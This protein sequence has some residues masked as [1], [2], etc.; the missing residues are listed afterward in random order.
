MPVIPAVRNLG[1]G[2]SEMC[3]EGIE[4]GGV[5]AVST[6][7]V[8]NSDK[9]FKKLCQNEVSD[10]VRLLKPES[11]IVYGSTEK[12]GYDFGGVPVKYISARRWEKD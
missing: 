9:D 11:L 4:P 2:T 12:M 5:Y 6:V 1:D 10:I 8:Y 7:G 3:F